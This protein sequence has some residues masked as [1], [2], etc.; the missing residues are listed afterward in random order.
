M[1][2]RLAIEFVCG[3]GI[4]S[5]LITLRMTDY[6]LTSNQDTHAIRLGRAIGFILAMWM[7][8][9]FLIKSLAGWDPP[10]ELTPALGIGVYQITWNAVALCRRSDPPWE[11]IQVHET[12]EQ[13]KCPTI[14]GSR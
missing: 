1:L 4:V 10:W 12:A 13:E 3:L 7:L 6:Y 5:S 11:S 9:Y 14:S 8:G 2:G